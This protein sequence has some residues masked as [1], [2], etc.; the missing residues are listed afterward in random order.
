[1]MIATPHAVGISCID[2]GESTRGNVRIYTSSYKIKNVIDL[3]RARAREEEKKTN[4]ALSGFGSVG[5][6]SCV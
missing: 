6:N 1:M 4:V 2:H 3:V 5:D